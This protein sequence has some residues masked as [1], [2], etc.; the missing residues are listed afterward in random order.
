MGVLAVLVCPSPWGIILLENIIHRV[1]EKSVLVRGEQNLKKSN[2]Q[3]SDSYQ[4][5]SAFS[6]LRNDLNQSRN[7]KCVNKLYKV[8]WGKNKKYVEYCTNNYDF[9]L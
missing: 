5:R 3:T 6:S 9:I 2:G 7:V 4:G 8:K 1:N